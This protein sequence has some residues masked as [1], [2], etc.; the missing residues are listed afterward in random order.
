MQ[1]VTKAFL[2]PTAKAPITSTLLASTGL[3]T[4]AAASAALAS[5]TSIGTAQDP[6]PLSVRKVA[7][8]NKG[9]AEQHW[10]AFVRLVHRSDEVGPVLEAELFKQLHAVDPAVKKVQIK[11]AFSAGADKKKGRGSVWM[12]RPELVAQWAPELVGGDG[13]AGGSPTVVGGVQGA[14]PM[15][16]G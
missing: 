4:A 2:C 9:L 14:G 11:A 7:L 15:V 13:G 10:P 16:M 12:C 1:H 5:S 3:P 8:Q 6:K